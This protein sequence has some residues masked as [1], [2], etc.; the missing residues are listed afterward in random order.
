M[1]ATKKTVTRKAAPK[2]KAT[3][4]RKATATAPQGKVAA[5]TP[6]PK[7]APA[8]K[9]DAK[10][11]EKYSPGKAA[12]NLKAGSVGAVIVETTRK[13]AMSRKQIIDAVI[14][15]KWTPPKSAAF[16]KNPQGYISGYLSSLISHKQL[17]VS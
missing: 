10:P 2:K 13:K 8:K 17:V 14:A 15:T 6:A 1:N 5:S 11:V 3:A 7:V 16:A 4:R 12:D 9:A